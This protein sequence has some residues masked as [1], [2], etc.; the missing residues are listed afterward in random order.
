MFGGYSQ[1]DNPAHRGQLYV[2]IGI[3]T[4]L[5]LLLA[6]HLFYFQVI[7][8]EEYRAHSER[9]RIRPVVLEAPRGLILDRNSVVLAD[10][11][12]SYTIAAAPFET[13]DETV[14]YL[15][16]LTGQDTAAIR[17]RI[18]DPAL[19]RFNPTPVLR[20]VSFEIASRVEEHLLDLPGVIVQITPSRMYVMGQLAS[21]VLGYVS[22]VNRQELEEL[23]DEGY[24]SGDIIGKL[25]VEK[26]FE[27]HL[28]GQ[29]GLEF[30]EVNASG[31]ELG[32]LS[33]MPVLLP[34]SGKKV[35]LTLDTRVQSV[36]EKAIP[37]SLAGALVAMDPM[38]GAV[39]A[40]VS[41][42]ARPGG[43]VISDAT[44]LCTVTTIRRGGCA[45]SRN[46][47]IVGEAA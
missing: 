6:V 14:D 16:E 25:G 5:F 12:A 21:H 2:F 45:D 28:R 17:K 19:N 7:S 40:I 43:A 36:A 23:K 9:N 34:E 18:R 29:S 13:S 44:S 38:S 27:Q 22:E 20:D 47:R 37:D 4:A 42:P 3:V 46:R 32:P 11:R 26:A 33:G 8:G 31:E 24:R 35:F 30:I 15:G 41:R 1:N 39:I 10:N